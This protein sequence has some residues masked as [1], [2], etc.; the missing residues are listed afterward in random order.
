VE[1]K[2]V[3]VINT[4]GKAAKEERIPYTVRIYTRKNH[5][6]VLNNRQSRFTMEVDEDEPP[7]L[8]ADD[9][10]QDG[11]D[12]VSAEMGDIA[13]AKVPITIVTGRK[14]CSFDPCSRFL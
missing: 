4:G 7:L 9:R 8:V 12:A 2:L 5:F 6:F 3:E 1:S 13:L 11:T 10:A 14:F